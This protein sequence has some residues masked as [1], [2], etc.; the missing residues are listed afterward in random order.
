[1]WR[2]PAGRQDPRAGHRDAPRARRQASRAHRP[3]A[4]RLAEMIS[5]ERV[6][7][8]TDCGF[9][10][11]ALTRRVSGVDAVGRLRGARR[12]RPDRERAH[13]RPAGG[14][15]VVRF[16]VGQ[17]QAPQLW[18]AESLVTYREAGAEGIGI[19]ASLG[20]KDHADDLA[21]LRESGLKAT[22]CIP[23]TTAHS[24]ARSRGRA[25]PGGADRGDVR[26]GA[27]A[28]ALRPGVLVGVRPPRPPTPDR[29][30]SEARRT[31]VDGLRRIAREA[32]DVGVTDRAR[33]DALL[34][35]S[36]VDVPD[37]HPPDTIAMLDEID[38]PNTGMLVDV[39]HLWDTPDLL[40]I[41]SA[42][43]ERVLGVHVDDWR[44]P[45]RSWAD[46]VL[47]GDGIGASRASSGPGSGRLR[48]LARGRDLL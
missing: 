9:A 47:P 23:S 10:P 24:P 39:W 17:F 29:D 26:G 19:D 20:L 12:G 7:A 34:D 14:V 5:P 25:R 16:S 38:E 32:A 4:V 44:D 43:V 6:Q 35:G 33:A 48:R 37:E 13:V 30:P 8:G 45:T 40:T 15:G 3:A 31:A 27:S 36:R 11:S 46:R 42:P 1:M 2:S 28:R 18:L 41:R 21:R 22:Y